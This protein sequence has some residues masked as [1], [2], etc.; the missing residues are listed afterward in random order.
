MA[1]FLVRN[2]INQRHVKQF[3]G[4]HY[5]DTCTCTCTYV[6]CTC[7]CTCTYPVFQSFYLY[8]VRM[9]VHAF[10]VVYTLMCCVVLYR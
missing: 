4:F 1:L 6:S 9:Y 5:T 7:A 2:R 8:N 10:C 3:I